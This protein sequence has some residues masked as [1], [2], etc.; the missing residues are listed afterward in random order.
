[1]QSLELL[2]SL[3]E[4]QMEKLRPREETTYPFLAEL[5]PAALLSNSR[6]SV[7]FPIILC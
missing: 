4:S 3:L 1:M 7:S 2:G 5:G 6:F